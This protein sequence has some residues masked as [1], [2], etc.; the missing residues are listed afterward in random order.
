MTTTQRSEIVDD[1]DAEA[2]VAEYL[3]SNP[4]FFERHAELLDALRLPHRTGAAVS[5]V[6]RQVAGLRNRNRK[7]ERQL[8]ELIGNARANEALMD[9][10]QGLALKLLKAKGLAQVLG[11]LETDLRERFDVD[12]AVVVW[13]GDPAREEALGLGRFLRIVPADDEA[14]GPFRTL[15][16]SGRPRCGRSRDSQRDFLFGEYADEAAS[17]AL[18]PL[19]P[20]EPVGILGLASRDPEHFHPGKSL[21]FLGRFG[22]LV[23]TAIRHAE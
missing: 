14:L 2:R 5:L 19:V 23:G 13:F 18:V 12:Q 20:P 7:L 10:L 9:K 6:E 1:A 8:A 4:D 17:V 15:L 22:E 21:D 11:A 3:A 16:E